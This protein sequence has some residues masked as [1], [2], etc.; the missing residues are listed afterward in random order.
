MLSSS[1]THSTIPPQ[2]PPILVAAHCKC[3]CNGVFLPRMILELYLSCS[4]GL[5]RCNL[6]STADI[7]RS[8]ARMFVESDLS[9]SRASRLRRP[10]AFSVFRPG[11]MHQTRRNFG[12][13]RK[14]ETLDYPSEC[15]GHQRAPQTDPHV[16]ETAGT[17]SVFPKTDSFCV[18]IPERWLHLSALRIPPLP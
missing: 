13:N 6:L 3:T 1:R 9:P 2:A 8:S 14:P 18:Q 7:P 4:L 17:S 5:N 10:V 12:P 16:P 15:N 11:K